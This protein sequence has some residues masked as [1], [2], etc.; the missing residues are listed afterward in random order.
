M[1]ENLTVLAIIITVF[2]LGALAYYYY[3]SRQ[4]GDIR[5]DLDALRSKLDEL[6]ERDS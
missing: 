6:E 4:L 1:V 5:E 2:W 3:T